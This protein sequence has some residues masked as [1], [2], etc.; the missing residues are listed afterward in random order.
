MRVKN[1]VKGRRE[2]IVNFAIALAFKVRTDFF[3]RKGLVATPAR[4]RVELQQRQQFFKGILNW[5]T[6]I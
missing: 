5:L 4:V 3:L 1:L 2:Q 6:P